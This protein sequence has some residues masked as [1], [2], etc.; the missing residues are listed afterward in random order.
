MTMTRA[1]S[2]VLVCLALPALRP[3]T[4]AGQPT[5]R[6]ADPARTP[7]LVELFT[8]EGCSSCPPADEA[9]A[10]LIA[11]QPVANAQIIGLEE[12]VDYWDHDGW[13]DPFSSSRFTARQADYDRGVFHIDPIYTP[14]A[15]VDGTLET[16]GSRVRLLE[17]SIAAAAR[18]PKARL[19]LSLI[20]LRNISDA[21]HAPSSV[22]IVVDFPPGLRW[23]GRGDL[24]LA[25]TEDGLS[26][27]VTAGENRNR[28]LRHSAVVRSLKRV[29]GIDG[30]MPI[31]VTRPLELQRGWSRSHLH[32][33]AFVQDR[34]THRVVGAASLPIADRLSLGLLHR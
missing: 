24:M 1:L 5:P 27:E 12:H 28:D 25:I 30:A 17:S 2:V 9:L 7:V 34:A 22:H 26:S 21:L 32:V 11:D 10:R 18:A 16:V 4:P 19:T 13:R 3:V 6:P 33:V 31:A 8:S 23:S 29:A 14:Q 20:G 15:I